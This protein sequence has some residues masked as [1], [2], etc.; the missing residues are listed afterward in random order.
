[1]RAVELLVIEDNSGDVALIRD[2]LYYCSVPV[3]VHVARDGEQALLMLSDPHPQLDL[4][5][6]DLNIPKV[7]GTVLLGRPM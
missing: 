5:I 7:P 6:L 2:S 1:M 3:R 4:V